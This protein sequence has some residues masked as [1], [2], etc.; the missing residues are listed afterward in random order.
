MIFWL[1]AGGY[2]ILAFIIG[3]CIK[4]TIISYKVEKE[5]EDLKDHRNFRELDEAGK[6]EY[7][8]KE[9]MRY[10]DA[11]INIK[12]VLGGL[13]WIVALPVLLAVG[14]VIYVHPLINKLL[15]NRLKSGVER[16]IISLKLEQEKAATQAELIKEIEKGNK[17]LIKKAKDAGLDVSGLE[18]IEQ[19]RELDSTSKKSKTNN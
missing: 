19:F 6:L 1:I 11:E 2:V 4:N 12:A 9:V 16:K 18:F 5:M 17:E 10:A 15:G 3:L 13:F 14:F 8:F 7:A